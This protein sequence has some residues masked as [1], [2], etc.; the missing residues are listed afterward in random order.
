MLK[1]NSKI[2]LEQFLLQTDTPGGVSL[3]KRLLLAGILICISASAVAE[4]LHWIGLDTTIRDSQTWKAPVEI[5]SS[6][7]LDTRVSDFWAS[8]STVIRGMFIIIR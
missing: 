1:K 7:S 5:T 3:A 8:V 6:C 4:E 2:E